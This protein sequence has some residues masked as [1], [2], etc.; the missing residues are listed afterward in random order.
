MRAMGA[1]SG[2]MVLLPVVAFA[3]PSPERGSLLASSLQPR[4]DGDCWQLGLCGRGE[5][6]VRKGKC[7]RLDD[8]RLVGPSIKNDLD[9]QSGCAMRT[10]GSV[11]MAVGIPVG[12]TVGAVGGA[13]WGFGLVGL[14]NTPS[15]SAKWSWGRHLAGRRVPRRRSRYLRR[16]QESRGPRQTE[17]RA[18]AD[19]ADRRDC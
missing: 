19:S 11:L 18:D 4:T 17:V 12:L 2:L 5:C 8:T 6:R 13:V 16:R 10:G 14:C 7:V 3:E 15:G 9:Y 1:L